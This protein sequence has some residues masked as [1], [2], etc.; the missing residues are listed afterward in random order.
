MS[1]ADAPAIREMIAT[2]LE[3][4]DTLYPRAF[5]Q[6]D[7]LALVRALSE[8]AGVFAL[9]ATLE[10]TVVGHVA[11]T[12]ATADAL[13]GIWL[14][15]PLCVAPEVQRQGI[16]SS[17]VAAGIER[18]GRAGAARVVV[19]GD[20]AYYARFGFT[21]E[22]RIMPPYR[23]PAAWTDAWQSLQIGAGHAGPGAEDARLML[24]APWLDPALWSP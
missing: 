11:V 3:A 24:P 15:G 18:I 10:R 16:G 14:L 5:P 13:R 23:L 20:P 7:L 1:P 4:L 17:L 9:V 19:L 22:R 8:T 2:D 12:P 21:A 6:E